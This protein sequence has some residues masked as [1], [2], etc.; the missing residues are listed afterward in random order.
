MSERGT[1]G[2]LRELARAEPALPETDVDELPPEPAQLPEQEG[3]EA[4]ADGVAPQADGTARYRRRGLLVLAPVSPIG[5]AC[6][7]CPTAATA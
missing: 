3:G 6:S 5:E 2:Q 4:A 7:N 1:R